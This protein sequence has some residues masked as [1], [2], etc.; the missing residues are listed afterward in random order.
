[1]GTDRVW[2]NHYKG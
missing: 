2:M 1:M